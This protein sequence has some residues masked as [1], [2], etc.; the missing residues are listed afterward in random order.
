MEE[1]PACLGDDAPDGRAGM[2]MAQNKVRVKDTGSTPGHTRGS[3][4]LR[5]KYGLEAR[6]GSRGRVKNCD[7]IRAGVFKG[8]QK[9]KSPGIIIS[10]NITSHHCWLAFSVAITDK[11][12]NPFNTE[13]YT[14]KQPTNTCR[15]QSWGNSRLQAALG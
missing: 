13:K 6:E 12:L 1:L 9:R 5:R 2:E 14:N 8:N 3:E 15:M 10:L 7:R 4:R 11:I